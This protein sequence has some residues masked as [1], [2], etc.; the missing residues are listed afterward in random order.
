MFISLARIAPNGALVTHHQLVRITQ[1][2]STDY[3]QVTIHSWTTEGARISGFSE[4]DRTAVNLPLASVDFSSGYAP[5]V[6]AAV[7][8]LEEWEGGVTYVFTDPTLEGLKEQKKAEISAERQRREFGTFDFD[9]RT[10]PI[11]RDRQRRLQLYALRAETTLRNS[12]ADPPTLM[13]DE[14]ST[15]VSLPSVDLVEFS[16]A[17]AAYILSLL[18]R[19][20]NKHTEIM[21]APD[22]VALNA[23]T[24]DS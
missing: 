2:F 1:E 23:I 21:A 3:L 19:E 18:D 12:A 4:V 16:A 5:G 15:I 17:L 20:R 6:L 14:D 8:A 9:S 10:W 24:W 11:D 7:V 22:I 13:V